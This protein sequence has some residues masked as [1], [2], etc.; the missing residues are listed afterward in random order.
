[1]VEEGRKER[2]REGKLQRAHLTQ[3]LFTKKLNGRIKFAAKKTTL[4]CIYRRYFHTSG[5]WKLLIYVSFSRGILKHSPP[6]S[7]CQCVAATNGGINRRIKL[8]SSRWQWHTQ[9]RETGERLRLEGHLSFYL[10]FMTHFSRLPPPAYF[11]HTRGNNVCLCQFGAD[12]RQRQKGNPIAGHIILFGAVLF[13]R[14]Q[15]SQ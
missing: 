7:P 2:K 11:H 6:L 9:K 15:F 4:Y 3:I 5:T 14:Q 8:K 1:M 12:K 10:H 13:V